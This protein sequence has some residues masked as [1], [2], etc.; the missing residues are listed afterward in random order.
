MD[1]QALRTK[2]C[3]NYMALPTPFKADYSLD[4]AALRRLVHRLLDAGYRTGNGVFL[5]AGA[6][7]EFSVL[8]MD[9]RRV[10]AETVV[11]EANGRIPVVVGVQDTS[12]RRVVELTCFARSI[13]ADAVQLSPPFYEPPSPDDILEMIRTVSDA[14]EIPI[15]V[16]NTWWT[17]VGTDVGYELIA[18]ILD[19]P[20]VGALKW[21]ASSSFVYEQV[22]RDF[23]SEVPMI[24]NYLSEAWSHMLGA[25]GFTSHPPFAWPEWG[26]RLWEHLQQRRYVQATE[27]LKQFRIPYYRLISKTMRYTGSEANV[28]KTALE[29]IGEPVGSVRPPARPLTQELREEVLQLLLAVGV[30]GVKE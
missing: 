24:D 14:A 5:V 18:K 25:T 13:G 16:Y 27:M 7:G 17:G 19:I 4:L 20:N 29:L 3:G 11:E 15:I 22:L 6:A 12:T 23:A 8:D 10:L 9:E 2:I 1:G 28:D 26:L 30:P 21:S